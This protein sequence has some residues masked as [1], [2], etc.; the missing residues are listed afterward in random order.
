MVYMLRLNRCFRRIPHPVYPLWKEPVVEEE[1]REETTLLCAFVLFNSSRVS[2]AWS[3]FSKY[4]AVH[5]PLHYH[6]L[7]DR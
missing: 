7:V 2:S 4:F 6:L 1:K 5:P 3:P